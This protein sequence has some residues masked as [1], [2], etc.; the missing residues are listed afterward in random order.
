MRQACDAVVR[1]GLAALLLFTPFAF[2]TVERWSQAL[3]EWGIALLVLAFA[4]GRS[5]EPQS[6]DPPGRTRTG[7]ELPIA[8]AI[9]LVAFQLVP[10]PPALLRVLSPGAAA[11]GTLPDL[12]K[13]IAEAGGS[14]PSDLA[15]RTAALQP[16]PARPIS[17]SPEETRDR[18]VMLIA[19]V[20]LFYLTAAWCDRVERAYWLAGVLTLIGALV[21]A[22]GLVQSFTWNERVL[23]FRRAPSS[24]Y[25]FGPFVNHN[26]F[27][28]FV[29]MI[30]PVA[31]GLG[32]SLFERRGRTSG[33]TAMPAGRSSGFG[34]TLHEGEAWSAASS[35]A[36]LALFAAVILVVALFFSLSRGGILS[37]LLSGS[38]L[39]A[40]S[41]RRL[42]SRRAAWALVIG[43]PAAVLAIVAWIGA[44][45]IRDRFTTEAGVTNEASFRAR[46]MVWSAAVRHGSEFLWVG[47]GLGAFEDSF[48]PY[49]PAGS[50]ARWDKAHN[51]YLQAAWE[52][53]LAGCALLAWAG[54]VFSRRYGWPALRQPGES[55]DFVRAGTALG[56]L[57]M[58][59]HSAVDFNLQI[60]A[61][62]ALFAILAGMLVSLTR[63]S[64]AP[65]ATAGVP[66]EGV[67]D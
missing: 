63:L 2:G 24:S 66:P 48:S 3:M 45:I 55:V 49:T 14:P 33:E 43:L 39:L 16:A 11:N 47:A 36:G 38:L 27:A 8:L 18:L 64:S 42:R 4:L 28:G 44:G 20:A 5:W 40:L 7:L 53:G 30:I 19:L 35:Q 67:H 46:A 61:N 52:V 22:V 60:G 9:A 54:V 58:A 26:H 51:D 59:L 25:A 50:W 56:L 37:F 13:A 34:G 62:G 21:S 32:L 10:L 23:W 31:I 12:G 6:G 57:S 15:E 65:G 17:V 29:E 1:W 41:W